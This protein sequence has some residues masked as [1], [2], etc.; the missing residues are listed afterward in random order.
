MIGAIGRIPGEV[1]H[2]EELLSVLAIQC[3]PEDIL[4]ERAFG[5]ST[6]QGSPKYNENPP[7]WFSQ[8]FF[9]FS[10]SYKTFA[11]RPFS[12]SSK[13]RSSTSS[14]H[15]RSEAVSRSSKYPLIIILFYSYLHQSI[16][17]WSHFYP[18][19]TRHM[20]MTLSCHNQTGLNYQFCRLLGQGFVSS[21]WHQGEQVFHH[22]M[23]GC[24]TYEW[25]HYSSPDS[26]GVKTWWAG[27]GRGL[28]DNR[29]LRH[30]SNSNVVFNWLTGPC[31]EA[32]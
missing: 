17:Y 5:Q 29:Q 1:F 21:K 31:T 12:P 24:I 8:P 22:L 4:T 13:L 7:G 6:R 14:C 19:R 23:V 15:I 20:R 10:Y 18:R 16:L 28:K 3:L 26:Q 27:L 9:I 11:G 32:Y 30:N 25:W 2:L